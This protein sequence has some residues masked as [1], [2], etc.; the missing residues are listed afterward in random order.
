MKNF[1]AMILC[2]LA[3]AGGQPSSAPPADP[4]E[5]PIVMYHQ[6]S[7]LKSQ[8]VL[9]IISVEELE[10]D[11]KWLYENGCETVSAQELR[12]FAAGRGQLPEKPVMLSFD[13]GQ[14]SFETYVLPLLEKYDMCAVVNIIGSLTDEYTKSG[15]TNLHYAYLSWDAVNRLIDSGRAEIGYHSYDM[16]ELSPRLG[17]SCLKDESELAY[18][19]KLESDIERFMETLEEHTGSTTSL[20]AYPY[21]IYCGLTERILEERGFDV[22]FTCSERVNVLKPGD[23]AALRELCR[24]NRAPGLS[25]ERFFGKLGLSRKE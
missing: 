8:G 11:I 2:A 14:L 3:L 10:N 22:M 23:P 5:L 12:E 19:L 6:V 4:V 15:D 20:M 24:F 13:D 18:R 7:E 16:H 17:L 25:S 21:G 1:S 9:Y